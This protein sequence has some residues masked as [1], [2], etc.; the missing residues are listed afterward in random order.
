MSE[1]FQIVPFHDHQ[2]LTIG[3]HD[4][5]FVV[6]KPIVEALGLAWN[7]Q[8]ERIKRHPVVSEG[9]RV[10]RIPSAGGVQEAISLELEQFHAWLATLSPERIKDDAKRELIIRYQREAFR[11][12]FEHFHG[13]IGSGR[14]R[15]AAALPIRQQNHYLALVSKLIKATN[16]VERAEIYSMLVAA[17]EAIGQTPPALDQLGKAEADYSDLMPQFWSIFKDLEDNGVI[18]NWHRKSSKIAVSPA[19]TRQVFAQRGINFP[20]TTGFFEAMRL[21]ID[22]LFEAYV[23]VNGRDNRKRESYVFLRSLRIL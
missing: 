11:A 12:I 20:L 5:V 7:A 13:K 21:S 9:M 15:E 22:P 19:H 17:G 8:L 4:G 16:K 6:M 10:T 14:S 3:A 2:L 23:K 1:N 18:M